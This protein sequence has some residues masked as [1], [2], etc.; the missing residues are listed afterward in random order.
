MRFS[1]KQLV[2][3]AAVAATVSYILCRWRGSSTDGADQE[4]ATEQQSPAAD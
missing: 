2:G 4:F 1:K 3:I